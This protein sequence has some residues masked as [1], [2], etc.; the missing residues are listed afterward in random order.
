MISLLGDY[1]YSFPKPIKLKYLLKD[2][3]ESEV[4]EKYYLSD[5]AINGIVNTTFNSSKLENIS[6]KSGI[7]PTLMARDYKD[8]KLV[9]VDIKQNVKIRKFDVDIKGLQFLLK[10]HKTLS[11]NEIATKL[12]VPLTTVEHWF[13]TDNGFSIPD[14]NIWF[15][16]KSMLNIKTNEFDKQITEFE[17]KENE[18]ESSNRAYHENG[19]SPTIT[20]INAPK[21]IQVGELN[22]KGN[23]T[24]KRVYSPQGLSPTLTTMEGGNRQPKVQVQTNIKNIMLNKDKTYFWNYQESNK[25]QK[26]PLENMARTLK[27]SKHDAGVIQN[28]RIRKL[29][30]RECW[31]LMG[32]S[33]EL[34]D[35][36]QAVNSNSQLY[37]QA[38]NSIVTTVL[39]AIFGEL[40]DV[41]WQE[42][43]EILLK[44]LTEKENE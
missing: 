43:V 30:P 34:F 23:D 41:D 21:I 10:E 19:L 16:L 12:D 18:F 6:E 32:F 22:I 37:K 1:Y 31:R 44:N 28:L 4:E 7:V 33:D 15:N 20:T 14:K 38:G 36:A 9:Q 35:K 29:T 25:F 2:F 5:K 42:K 11:N 26:E 40:L 3:L 39:M 24:I 17:I 13:R 8:P 27:A